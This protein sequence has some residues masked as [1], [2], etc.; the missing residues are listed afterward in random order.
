MRLKERLKSGWTH[1]PAWFVF[2][3]GWGILNYE[4]A[5]V[6]P[7][8]WKGYDRDLFALTAA[9]P[10][11]WFVVYFTLEIRREGGQRWRY[12]L[13]WVLATV[14]PALTWL[15]PTHVYAR[16][17]YLSATEIVR[18]YEYSQFIWVVV[19]A[20]HAWTTRSV[21]R[22]L[23][24]F[25]VCF[26]YGLLL[27]NAGII[28]GFFSEHHYTIYI[29]A[30]GF[31]LPAPLATQF[32]WCIMF[33]VAVS[34]AE[35]IG[36]SSSKLRCRPWAMALLTAL[37]ATTLDMQIDPMASLSGVWWAWDPRLPEAFLSVPMIN[38]V[39]WFAA[40]LPFSFAYF[41]YERSDLPQK[42]Q[43]LRMLILVPWMFLS[44]L[45]IGSGPMIA[46]EGGFGGPSHAIFMEFLA[47]ILPY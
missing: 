28:L 31:R 12:I 18:I 26:V 10:M 46:Y 11:L 9:F 42:K 23:T 19:L 33:Y 22:M 35:G 38:F 43:N 40:F 47:K 2:M 25:G 24:F 4:M 7:E 15:V 30:G 1:F 5:K 29:E 21:Q 16:E 8:M 45:L 14:V 20:L 32:G 34:L 3:M 27:E 44:C 36:R 39:A 41:T 13:V 17:D 37:I 6:N